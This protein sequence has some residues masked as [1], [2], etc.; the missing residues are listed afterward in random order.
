MKKLLVLTQLFISIGAVAQ[1]NPGSALNKYQNLCEQFLQ[2]N[3]KWR[4]ANKAYEPGNEWSASYWGY[5]FTRG[6]NNTT[7]QLNIKGYIPKKAEWV[8]FWSGFYTWNYKTNQ[9]NY[10]SVNNA[11]AVAG[12]VSESI[13]GNELALAFTITSPGGE[14]EQHRDKHR[15]LNGNIVSNS[16][17]LNKGKWA[18]RN[19]QTWVPLEQP[20]GK[21]VFM[22]TR[23]GNFEIY[24]MEANGDS[25]KNL[26]CNKATDYSFGN[27]ADGRILFYS[28]REGNDEVYL[29]SKD[30]K[31]AVNLTNHPRADRIASISPNGQKIVFS[32]YRDN[33]MPELYVMNIDGS[34][35]TRLTNND[36]FEDAAEW[37]PDGQ[38]IV[39][40]RDIKPATDTT[41]PTASNGEIFIM[42]AD[43]RNVQQLTNRPGF[44]GGPK[45]SPNG[46]RIAFYGKTATGHYDLFIMNADGSQVEN[47]TEDEMEDYSPSWSPDG[48]WIAFTRGN[49]KNYDV[50]IINLETRIKYRLTTQPKRDESPFWF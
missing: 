11:G 40:S 47:I 5:E 26:S 10:Y 36:N 29:S 27:T 44:D 21:L 18:P 8:S 2:H 16:F 13:T 49:A 22:S 46:R 43:G 38:K 24:S 4:T 7:L 28:N 14:T 37:S 1:N 23:D 30:G 31:T 3:G 12:G 42:D 41:S 25:I 17:K 19:T 35:V 45:F 48:R 20:T 50:W 9:V 34:N 32:S 39:F 33:P 6:I 15:F